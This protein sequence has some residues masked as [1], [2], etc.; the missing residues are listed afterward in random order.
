MKKNILIIILIILFLAL[1]ILTIFK[2][3][4]KND[5][6]EN[7]DIKELTSERIEELIYD[8]YI[9]YMLST[10]NIEETGITIKLNDEEYYGT[11]IKVESLDDI[12]NMIDDMI[13]NERKEIL[14]Q[15]IFGNEQR[16]FYYD[17]GVLFT[18]NIEKDE[19]CDL[20]KISNFGQYTIT[21]I[22]DE[23]V[24]IKY[25]MMNTLGTETEV[26]I[27][28]EEGKWKLYDVI[29]MCIKYNEEDIT[30]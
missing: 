20:E 22:N 30:N 7:N 28:Y 3:N 18:N 6:K 26:L 16:Q 4:Y 2:I 19:E 17:N 21:K 14:M 15:N 27:T 5:K 23:N 10:G 1:I 9:Y 13:V 12:D 8:S 11:N 24:K 29:P 25:D